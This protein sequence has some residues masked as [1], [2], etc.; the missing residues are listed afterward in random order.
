[1]NPISTS[2]AGMFAP[3]RTR[4]GACWIGRGLNGTRRPNSALTKAA[5]SAD[6]VR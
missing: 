1:M 6:G 5:R 4:N 3:T 2:I